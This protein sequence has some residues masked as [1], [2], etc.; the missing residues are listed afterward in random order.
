FDHA[1]YL[2]EA[3]VTSVVGVGYLGVVRCGGVE[4]AQQPHLVGVLGVSQQGA[5]VLQ[6]TLVRHQQQVGVQV[7]GA[8]LA[9]GVV[10]AVAVG[11]QGGSGPRV[12]GLTDVPGTGAH[13]A[14]VHPLGQSVFVQPVPQ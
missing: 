13:A 11:L 6:M 8:D 7:L 1:Q 10:D 9:G 5:H 2:H 14:D 4:A 12:C 3:L